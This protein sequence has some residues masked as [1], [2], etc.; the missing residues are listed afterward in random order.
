MHHDPTLTYK[1]SIKIKGRK[2]RVYL[3]LGIRRML[4][5]CVKD[6]LFIIHSRVQKSVMCPSIADRIA[7]G[8]FS[9]SLTRF[10]VSDIKDL[11]QQ[12][13]GTSRIPFPVFLIAI[14]CLVLQNVIGNIII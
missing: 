5:D 14:S 2:E 8:R 11:S 7:A 4:E 9:R 3:L 12:L 10:C 13:G 1:N 6:T